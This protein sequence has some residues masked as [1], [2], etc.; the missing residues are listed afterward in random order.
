[1]FPVTNSFG[2]YQRLCL[3]GAVVVIISP[4]VRAQ[5]I[6]GT[7]HDLSANGNLG[8]QICEYCHTPHSALPYTPLWGRELTGT[9]YSMYDETASSTSDIPA[10][11]SGLPDGSSILCL[12]CHDG[13]IAP[14]DP[15]RTIPVG[16]SAVLGSDLRDDHPVSFVYDA[17]LASSDGQLKPA[18]LFPADL[19]GNRK[20]QCTSCHDPH[21]DQHGEF[22]VNSNENSALCHLCH[23]RQQWNFSSH[24]SSSASW[25]GSGTDPWE[26]LDNAFPSVSQNG[27]GN[28]HDMHSSGGYTR[29]LKTSPDEQNC[30]DCH[31]GNVASADRNIEAQLSKTYRHDVSG[32]DLVHE[33]NEPTLLNLS[34]VHVE[35]SDC[36]DP[37]QATG[38]SATAPEAMGAI[39][40]VQGVD[41]NGLAKHP[42]QY[43][44]ELCFRCHSDYPVTASLISR[45]IE[46]ANTRLE[47]STSAV[48]FHPV[49][50]EGR[51]ADVPSL[52]PPLSESSM[53]YCTDCHASNG[54]DVPGGPHGSIYPRLLKYQYETADYTPESYQAYELCYSCHN[55]SQLL[56]EDGDNVQ[57]DVHYLHVVESRTPCSVCHDPHGI[58]NAQGNSTN[59][60]HLINFDTNVVNSILGGQIYFRDDGYR[61]GSCVL[62]CHNKGHNS[63]AY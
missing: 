20:L 18:P 2:L 26:H 30:L 1:M 43:E 42:I 28:C 23:E 7:A 41:Q 55:R 22:L 17:A 4:D 51:N 59:N 10:N 9:I 47:F 58:S 40:G 27:C 60:T 6:A 39:S 57:D 53:L 48:S 34:Q 31:N 29:L 16:S 12:S 5:S 49:E 38:N 21:D 50:T 46:Q 25:N 35:C 19:D 11:P 37:H 62:R 32:Y 56:N 8:N 33:P 44:Y 24:S 61:T 63:R 14:A 45:K 52:I 36:H 54:T 15:Q 13:T 3:I